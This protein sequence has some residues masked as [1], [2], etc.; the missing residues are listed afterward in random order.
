METVTDVVQHRLEKWPLRSLALA[1]LLSSTGVSIPNVALPTLALEFAATF[2]EVQWIILIYLL[3]MTVMTVTAG[4]LGDL[5]GR[6][7]VLL[8]GIL[9]FTGAAFLCCFVTTL[10]MFIGTRAIQGL[11]AA[12]IMALT[13][14]SVRETVSKDKVGSAMGLM[15]TMSAVGTASGPSIGGL[16]ISGFGWRGAFFVMAVLGLVSF[17]LALRFLPLRKPQVVLESQGLDVIGTWLL[18]ATLAAYSLGV[19]LGGGHWSNI[20]WVLLV[21]T[22]IG[23]VLFL[24]AETKLGS[25]LVRLSLFRNR[26]ISASLVMNAIVATVMMSTL[27]VG[28]F[29]LSRALGLDTILVGVVMSVGPIMSILTGIPSGR[30][31]DR[32]GT[33]LVTALGLGEMAIGLSALLFLPSLFGWIGYMIS[34]AI[35]SPGYQLFQAANNTAVMIDVESEER[36]VIAGL[37]NLSRNLGL[38]TGAS[39]MG[40]VFSFAS[41]STRISKSSSHSV[42]IGM[43]STFLVDICLIFMALVIAIYM[44]R[45]SIKKEEA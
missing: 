2:S 35:L 32:F 6:R 19:T 40:A 12:L 44:N 30:F 7:K 45:D 42:A 9:L 18:G 43:K 22:A 23:L 33:S 25:P 17:F 10:W 31:V 14:A 4:R 15:G 20:N 34:V 41:G 26:G 21:A 29:Y 24:F 16:V 38:I 28:P 1:M 27:V 5:Y 36:G 13:L 3:V 8:I 11:G 39:V 37:L